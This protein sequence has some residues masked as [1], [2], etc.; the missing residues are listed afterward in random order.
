MATFFEH[1]KKSSNPAI[2]IFY[3]LISMHCN[4]LNLK[5]SGR[6]L[7]ASLFYI[8]LGGKMDKNVKNEIKIRIPIL[9]RVHNQQSNIRIMSIQ[10]AQLNK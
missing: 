9:E 10:S 3:P 6:K 5:Y 8:I 4:S 2:S 7:H 1:F